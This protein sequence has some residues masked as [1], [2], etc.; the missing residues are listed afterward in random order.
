MAATAIQKN[1]KNNKERIEEDEKELEEMRKQALAE[2][3]EDDQENND[4]Q[5]QEKE[6]EESNN[7]QEQIDEEEGNWKKRYSDLRRHQ[8]KKEQELKARI[9]EL[10][11]KAQS[12]PDITPQEMPKTKKELEEWRN[13][14]PDIA[15]IVEEIAREQAD[16]MFQE[17]KKQLDKYDEITSDLSYAQAMSKI[18]K[19]HSDLDSLLDDQKFHDWVESKPKWFG[20]M[21]YD[22]HEDTE[23]VIEILNIYKTENGLTKKAK[24]QSEK[25]AAKS[26]GTRSKPDVKTDGEAKLK[27]S[28][29]EAM[30][31]R[32]YESRYEE[33]K[34]LRHKGMIEYDIS[35]AAR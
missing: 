17:A 15:A 10:E 22:Q 33:I 28:E 2:L 30:T 11:K 4:N 8:T 27:E 31:E 26:V 19:A 32:E 34:E 6:E 1:Y 24:K 16:E 5:T 18:R 13:K 20:E 23:A 21:I 35:G 14:Y 29:I 25:D 9:E 3:N 7:Q 12:T